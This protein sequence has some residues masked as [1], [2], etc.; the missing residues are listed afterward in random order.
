MLG[1]QATE[2]VGPTFRIASRA[3]VQSPVVHPY[4]L[5]GDTLRYRRS[6]AKRPTAS[7]AK[8]GNQSVVGS[9]ISILLKNVRFLSSATP[10]LNPNRS[11]IKTPLGLFR[12]RDSS[13]YG[14]FCYIFCRIYAARV[15]GGG[16][17]G[18]ETGMVSRIPRR[19]CTLHPAKIRN[20]A[21]FDRAS[22]DHSRH[23]ARTGRPSLSSL[24]PRM[25]WSSGDASAPTL[26]R[27]SSTDGAG[28]ADE[29]R[30]PH[31]PPAR[32]TWDRQR[33]PLDV[34]LR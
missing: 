25:R 22:P 11:H 2:L 4:N 6:S 26:P 29:R 12:G 27:L 17:R 23:R 10:A 20:Y 31:R 16:L 13:I 7:R 3:S 1:Y 19:V 32:S 9:C 14:I 15:V 28:S 24:L 21:A 33:S 8:A 34:G 5:R 30:R 18:L